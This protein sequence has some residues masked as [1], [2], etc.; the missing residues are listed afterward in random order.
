ME[1]PDIYVLMRI[2]W[3]FFGTLTFKS[4]KLPERVRV[5]MF[6]AL[7][8]QVAKDFG[9]YFPALPW[10]L[11]KERGEISGRLHCHFLLAGLPEH[12]VS[13][14]TCFAMMAYWE[15][16]RGGIP[17]IRIFDPHLNGVDYVAKCLG[18]GLDGADSYE[19]AK[20]G[21]NGSELLY[22][23]AVWDESNHFR[24]RIR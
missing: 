8:R 21:S 12:A 7:L 1:S 23:E 20:F 24:K 22:A 11:R 9:L 16:K 3:Q 19:S 15:K 18:Q 17:R 13:Q 10:C 2:R 4:E 6:Y 5:G 14:K